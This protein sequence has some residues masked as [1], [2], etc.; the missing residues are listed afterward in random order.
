MKK[1]ILINI[2][3]LTLLTGFKTYALELA[4]EQ[5]PF[6]TKNAYLA[7]V[8]S[9]FSPYEDVYKQWN[10]KYRTDRKRIKAVNYTPAVS[11][12]AYV[13]PKTKAPL[14]II[15]PGVGGEG[16][17]A[18]SMA[19]GNAY[20]K[21]GYHVL[22]LP[23]NLSWSYSV[24]VSEQAAPGYMPRDSVEYYNLMKWILNY[25][26][27]K[28]GMDYSSITVLGYSNGG[29]LAAFLATHDKMQ[30]NPLFKKI[31]LINPAM[32]VMYGVQKLDYMNDVI[33]SKIA[34]A[35]KD[36][37]MGAILAEA[38]SI[39]DSKQDPINA[40][41]SF[42][43]KYKF[44]E[45]HV[46]WLIGSE[47]RKSLAAIVL[48]TQFIIDRGLLT[49]PYSNYVLNSRTEQSYKVSFADYINKVV[50]PSLPKSERAKD[51]YYESSIYSQMTKLKKDSRVFVFTNTDDFII[52]PS[53]VEL[54]KTS[55]KDRLTLFP[56][57]GHLGNALAPLNIEMY[58]K[59][60]Q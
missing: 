34:P 15:I 17:S 10:L 22:A 45:Q 9:V 21:Q 46:Q 43:Q 28:K 8:L 44:K 35:K 32:D 18:L 37:I 6:P 29:L 58:L 26:Q 4:P 60:S 31:L 47:Y 51:V 36:F 19:I 14:L 24:S 30:Q 12:S 25:A 56:F 7:T 1:L 33:G 16:K 57:G 13:Q 5:Y 23:S 2:Y 50:I 38:E 52:K 39:I 3:F 20:I 11:V 42:M 27:T 48:G 54:L 40:L 55:F 41:N 53:D 49:E 59:A